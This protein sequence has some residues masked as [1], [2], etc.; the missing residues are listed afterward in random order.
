MGSL[1][2]SSATTSCVTLVLPLLLSQAFLFTTTNHAARYNET[3][4]TRC[5]SA[6]RKACRILCEAVK[7]GAKS[8]RQLQRS[9]KRFSKAPPD[10]SGEEVDASSNDLETFSQR[11]ARTFLCEAV[12][13]E[14]GEEVEKRFLKGLLVVETSVGSVF[15]RQDAGCSR[16]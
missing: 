1:Y 3:L 10:V 6:W 4:V 5:D 7:N 12:S 11:P 16:S 9:Q 13:E 2:G 14:R 15:M 8:R